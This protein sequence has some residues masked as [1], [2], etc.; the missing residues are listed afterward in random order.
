MEEIIRAERVADGILLAVKIP[1][2]EKNVT[3]GFSE[4]VDREINALHLLQVPH[5]Y[6]CDPEARI[7]ERRHRKG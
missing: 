1:G 7:I 5:K 6:L 3:F 4:L 2:G